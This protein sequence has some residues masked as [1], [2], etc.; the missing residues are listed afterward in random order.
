MS[1]LLES[2]HLVNPIPD[3]TQEHRAEVRKA[4]IVCEIA[5]YRDVYGQEHFS[6]LM[7]LAGQRVA[8]D[9]ERERHEGIEPIEQWG[10]G[11]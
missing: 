11:Q 1:H 2:I 7:L 3:A 6:E 5:E 4:Q 9:V 10:R 8:R